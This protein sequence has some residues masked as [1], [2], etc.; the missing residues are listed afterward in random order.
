[1]REMVRIPIGVVISG[2]TA[3]GSHCIGD[4]SS[5][6]QVHPLS[7]EKEMQYIELEP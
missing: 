3:T 1:M 6:H 5:G 4:C 2:L 7:E